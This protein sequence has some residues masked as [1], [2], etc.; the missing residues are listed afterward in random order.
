VSD[1]ATRGSTR[2]DAVDA[3]DGTFTQAAPHTQA[4]ERIAA[5]IDD[6]GLQDNVADLEANGFTVVEDAAP[7]VL[8]DELRAAI[9]EVTEEHRARGVTPFDF[10]P[11]TSM[12]YRLLAR[13][14][15][16]A[17]AVLSP[18]LSALVAFLLGEGYVSQVTTGSI[19]EQGARAGP[20]HSDN[21]FFPEPFPEQAHVATAIWCCDPFDGSGGST[22][23]VPASHR[24]LRHPRPG[25][26]LDEAIPVVAD[27]GSV[28]LW[29]GHTW[30]RSGSRTLPGQ[31]VA[32]HTAFSRPHVRA[33][34]AY[35]LDEIERL[36][37][38]DPR[39][40]RLVGADLP[41]DST[42]DSPDPMKLLALAAT[43]QAQA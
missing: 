2:G 1:R 35:T 11:N 6:L 33:F 5:A 16:F 42:G 23:L 19:L 34:E 24:L 15:V 18:K 17:R 36:V 13:D 43:T 9:V 40:T 26:G 31:R 3:L 28:V 29:S 25:E 4:R 27:A 37:D 20:L 38:L 21:Q 7:R 14:E 22:H 10:G 41:N 8:F 30:H 32:L 39:F 12:V